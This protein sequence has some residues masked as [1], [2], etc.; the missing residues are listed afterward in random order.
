MTRIEELSAALRA[1][2]HE[3][4]V[5]TSRGLAVDEEARALDGVEVHVASNRR[6]TDL[7]FH[8]APRLLP[9]Q[10]TY[11]LWQIA[12]VKDVVRTAQSIGDD[13]CVVT[14]SQA[15]RYEWAAALAPRRAQ[16]VV[17]DLH[18]RGRRTVPGRLVWRLASAR[19][20]RRQLGG[21]RVARVRTDSA[22]PLD[23]PRR[24][25][26]RHVGLSSTVDVVPVDREVARRRLGLDPD[27]RIALSFGAAHAGKDMATLLRACSG[28]DAAVRLVLAGRGVSDAMTV[29]ERTDPGLDFPCVTVFDGPQSDAAKRLL[30]SA[31]DVVV[32]AR[33]ASGEDDSSSLTDAASYGL[34]VVCSDRGIVG[35]LVRDYGLGTLFPSGSATELRAA[36]AA[37]DGSS[38]DRHGLAAFRTEHSTTALAGQLIELAAGG[39]SGPV[40]SVDR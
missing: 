27:A 12:L 3:V 34:G 17:Y 40:R 28:D 37:F 24:L 29:I 7:D 11:A 10:V 36:L 13:V 22:T 14:L 32:I 9:H 23:E 19:E 6:A 35:Q 25:A 5:L 16:W 8:D 2:G 31:A 30:Y 26:P 1:L 15:I 39:D 33:S 20:R 4:H 21:G 38:V 18:R